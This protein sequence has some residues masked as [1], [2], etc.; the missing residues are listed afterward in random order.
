MSNQDNVVFNVRERPL[1]SDQNNVESLHARTLAE[2]MLYQMTELNAIDGTS[3]LRNVVLGGL[4]V[5]PNGSNVDVT[6]GVLFQN[7]GS[8]VPTPG[9]YDSSYR[10]G[11]NAS[12]ST[13]TMASP[14]SD[15]YYIIE[16]EGRRDSRGVHAIRR[17]SQRGKL[18]VT[19]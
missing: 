13:L 16:L 1:S 10:Y 3:I 8:L 17:G 2:M 11:R 18:S 14:A 4:A 6:A 12:S 5:V 19:E 9:T 15:T 7:S